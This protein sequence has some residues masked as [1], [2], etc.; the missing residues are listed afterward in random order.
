[1]LDGLFKQLKFSSNIPSNSVQH[2][3]KMLDTNVG[4]VYVGLQEIL[5]N[6]KQKLPKGVS[7]QISQAYF[8][9]YTLLFIIG[10][11]PMINSGKYEFKW[12]TYY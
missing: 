10:K 5:W 8:G 6:Q 4:P 9:E 3:K 7:Q 2:D 11:D 1:M 12:R